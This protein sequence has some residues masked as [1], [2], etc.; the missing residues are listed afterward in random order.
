MYKPAIQI[1]QESDTR[2]WQVVKT[3]LLGW[4]VLHSVSTREH[5]IELAV[6]ARRRLS[7]VQESTLFCPADTDPHDEWD[8]FH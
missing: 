8:D 5:A 1:V 6:R 4:T 2:D 3:K 7:S